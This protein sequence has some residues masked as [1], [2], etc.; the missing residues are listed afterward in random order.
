VREKKKNSTPNSGRYSIVALQSLPLPLAVLRLRVP[1]PE[2]T[3]LLL[4]QAE[5][6]SRHNICQSRCAGSVLGMKGSGLRLFFFST[7]SAP[8]GFC[9]RFFGSVPPMPAPALGS[10]GS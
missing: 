8:L 9:F 1:N 7:A 2:N 4:Q 3:L 10:A 5:K 6:T